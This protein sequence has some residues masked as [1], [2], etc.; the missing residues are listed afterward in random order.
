MHIRLRNQRCG[1]EE[2]QANPIVPFR[3]FTFEFN[4][5]FDAFATFHDFLFCLRCDSSENW[6]SWRT[7]YNWLKWTPSALWHLCIWIRI[8]ASY[9]APS[10]SIWNV[11]LMFTICL[12]FYSQPENDIQRTS[13]KWRHSCTLKYQ[14]MCSDQIIIIIIFNS[15]LNR[16]RN[17]KKKNYPIKKLIC[18]RSS[19]AQLLIDTYEMQLAT[20]TFD[21][22]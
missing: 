16:S 18:I 1:C 11:I 20:S 21:I 4:F 8:N 17:S 13:R 22:D 7:L 15:H 14:S 5:S 9:Q 2:D 3:L 12:L 10:P 19:G 6:C